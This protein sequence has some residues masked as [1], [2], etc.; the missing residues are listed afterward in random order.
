MRSDRATTKGPAMTGFRL[1][2]RVPSAKNLMPVPYSFGMM[3][4]FSPGRIIP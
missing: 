2:A 3:Y 4:T 1:A